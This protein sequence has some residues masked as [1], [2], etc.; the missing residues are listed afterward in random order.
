MHRKEGKHWIPLN[1]IDNFAIPNFN[2]NN[3]Y[4]T[5][6]NLIRSY[7]DETKKIKCNL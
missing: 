7:H 5:S 1:G 4:C 3:A 6:L 2:E